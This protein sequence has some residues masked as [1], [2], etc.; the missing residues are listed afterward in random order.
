MTKPLCSETV[1]LRGKKVHFHALVMLSFMSAD[2]IVLLSSSTH[3]CHY[4]L[5]IGMTFRYLKLDLALTELSVFQPHLSRWLK[6]QTFLFPL[7]FTPY[8]QPICKSC[9]ITF[10]IYTESNCVLKPLQLPPRSKSPPQFPKCLPTSTR[11]LSYHPVS[12]WK[13]Q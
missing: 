12:T 6:S 13:P 2:L 1:N 8:I 11:P 5:S 10:K 9:L 3:L 7:S 4:Y